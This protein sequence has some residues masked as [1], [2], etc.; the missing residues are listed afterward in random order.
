[1][2]LIHMPYLAI[3]AII[4]YDYFGSLHPNRTF[5]N[6]MN[7]LLSGENIASLRSVQGDIG[8]QLNTTVSELSITVVHCVAASNIVVRFT[9]LHN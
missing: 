2:L 1:M 3:T 8:F 6:T 4:P 9:A 7:A 5:L